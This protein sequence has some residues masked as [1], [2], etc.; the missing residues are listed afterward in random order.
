LRFSPAIYFYIII[1]AFIQIFQKRKMSKK[2]PFFV[3]IGTHIPQQ[4]KKYVVAISGSKRGGQHEVGPKIV[5]TKHSKSQKSK[6]YE[7]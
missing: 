3:C 6:N 5:L 4:H 1:F 2:M 7:K